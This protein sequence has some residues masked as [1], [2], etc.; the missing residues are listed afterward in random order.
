VRKKA[1]VAKIAIRLQDK[2]PFSRFPTGA[3]E[4]FV[5]NAELM[6]EV[7]VAESHKRLRLTVE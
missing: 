4:V 6:L 3:R 2:L 7:L 5:G 1:K